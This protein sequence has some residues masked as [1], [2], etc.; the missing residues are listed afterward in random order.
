MGRLMVTATCK[1]GT[2]TQGAEALIKCKGELKGMVMA[3]LV[4]QVLINVVGI[5]SSRDINL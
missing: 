5:L 1:D 2:T 3:G 4:V